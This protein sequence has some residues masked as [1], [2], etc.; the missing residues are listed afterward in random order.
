LNEKQTE[1]GAPSFQKGFLPEKR[2]TE[3]R[4]KRVPFPK[5]EKRQVVNLLSQ[6]AIVPREGDP[7]GRG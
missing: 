5:E 4:K 6:E 3:K 1:T 2:I 7:E